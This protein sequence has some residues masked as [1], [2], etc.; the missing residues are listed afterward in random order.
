MIDTPPILA[1]PDPLVVARH[2][3]GVLLVVRASKTPRDYVTKSIQLLN[4]TKL[5]GIV[6]NG[7]EL[8]M[9][10]KYYYYSY[11]PSS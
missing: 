5:M 1:T 6:L 10:S 11:T 4:S 2:V 9:G 3:D 7:A 8:G